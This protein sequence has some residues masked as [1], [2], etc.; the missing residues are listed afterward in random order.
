MERTLIVGLG[1]PGSQYDR[2]RHNIGFSVI[3]ALADELRVGLTQKKFNGVYGQGTLSLG[4]PVTLLKPQTF[5][6]LS[7]QSVAPCAQFFKIPPSRIIVI[8]DELEFPFGVIRVKLGGGSA[9]HN[10]LKSIHS[11][12][13][14]Q[15]FLR[16]RVGIGR[17]RRGGVSS[18][19]LAPF[20][21]DETPWIDDL[22]QLAVQD[23][24]TVITQ[25]PT[26]AMNTIHARPPLVSEITSS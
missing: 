4:A 5:M 11:S 17:P 25:G 24:S 12:L 13:G 9:G 23:V 15:A 8:H 7:G 18:Y 21:S 10:G 2:T 14:T 19:V 3:D 26:Q 20:S 16:L 6:N 22:C 1:N